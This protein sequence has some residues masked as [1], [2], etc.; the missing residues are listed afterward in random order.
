VGSARRGCEWGC[1]SSGDEGG[2][3]DVAAAWRGARRGGRAKGLER[4]LGGG[5]CALPWR[6]VVY[7]TGMRKPEGVRRGE[8]RF[9]PCPMEERDTGRTANQPLF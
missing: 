5:C 7:W 3:G 2:E 9:C 8:G 6:R 1:G 4:R